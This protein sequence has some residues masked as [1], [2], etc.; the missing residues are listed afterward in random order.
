MERKSN[1]ESHFKYTA[2][3]LEAGIRDSHWIKVCCPPVQTH[4]Q[5]QSL[6]SQWS[7]SEEWTSLKCCQALSLRVPSCYWRTW[8]WLRWALSVGTW[9]CWCLTLSSS[10]KA[11]FVSCRSSVLW[12]ILL[13][14][15]TK[16]WTS[17]LHPV[18]RR[19][20]F[21]IGRVGNIL[22]RKCCGLHVRFVCMV[23]TLRMSW[24]LSK[25]FLWTYLIWV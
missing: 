16:L 2:G 1:T 6:W 5:S 25:H 3:P 20:R 21:Y 12:R 22:G 17:I 15:G 13:W 9:G 14:F 4:F 19:V 7:D 24:F 23:L 18:R 10:R 8:W 11:A